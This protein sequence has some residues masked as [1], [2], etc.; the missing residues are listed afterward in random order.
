MTG[1]FSTKAKMKH[2]F[3]ETCQSTQSSFKDYWAQH[4]MNDPHLLV[5]TQNQIAGLGRRGNHWHSANQS[6]AMSF[7]INA[8]EQISLTPLHMALALCEYFKQQNISL[9][10]K[11]PND[12]LNQQG[13]KVGGI[14][15]QVLDQDFVLVGIGLN[16]YFDQSDFSAVKE[17]S[18]PINHLNLKAI[19]KKEMAESLYNYIIQCED[20]SADKWN[21]YCFHLNKNVEIIDGDQ[22]IKGL[23]TGIDK[24]GAAIIQTQDSTIKVYTGSLRITG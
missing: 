22:R 11:W 21:Q 6:L 7:S 10:L 8:Q 24:L 3:L 19:N 23:F 15:C 16:L 13:E 5:S 9:S 2:H 20:F 4:D 14:L 12:I 1:A 17:L 18:Y